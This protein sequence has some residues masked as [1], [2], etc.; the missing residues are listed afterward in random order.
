MLLLSDLRFTKGFSFHNDPH[1]LYT[2]A[3]A[4]AA[5]AA[6]APQRPCVGRHLATGNEMRVSG[7]DS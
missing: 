2:S 7:S 5:A 4:A 3:A 1:F 6:A